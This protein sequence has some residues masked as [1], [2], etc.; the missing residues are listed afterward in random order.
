V[1]GKGKPVLPS[2]NQDDNRLWVDKY[3]PT[4]E[5]CLSLSLSVP[6]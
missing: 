4:I 6:S 2:V 1:K 3:E 5:V